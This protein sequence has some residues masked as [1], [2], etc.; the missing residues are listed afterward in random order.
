M[1]RGRWGETGVGFQVPGLG[2][3]SG[4]RYR[5]SGIGCRVAGGPE[6]MQRWKLI[7]GRVRGVS[8]AHRGRVGKWA[9]GQG[10]K[11]ETVL[12]CKGGGRDTAARAEREP[13][14]RQGE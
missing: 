14:S 10:V 4:V 11:Q 9:G 1:A 5:V 13:Y 12:R 7:R 2:R 6:T 3:V 8:E